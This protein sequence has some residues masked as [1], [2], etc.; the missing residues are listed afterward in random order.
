MNDAI[1]KLDEGKIKADIFFD[2][3]PIVTD[4][5]EV[6]RQV[7]SGIITKASAL[8]KLKSYE[9]LEESDLR[10]H[11]HWID[12][13]RL[14]LALLH[15]AKK[16][17][18]T[19][20]T[21]DLCATRNSDPY[22]GTRGFQSCCLRCAEYSHQEPY[23]GSRGNCAFITPAFNVR[24]Q[25]WGILYYW[26]H[27]QDSTAIMFW[28]ADFFKTRYEAEQA[29]WPIHRYNNW[30]DRKYNNLMTYQRDF[31]TVFPMSTVMQLK[32]PLNPT[33]L[34]EYIRNAIQVDMDKE[35]EMMGHVVREA[36][37]AHESDERD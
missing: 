25:C 32:L 18:E 12:Q 11:Q 8:E 35:H 24:S 4:W 30:L 28:L 5:D 34:R 37:R 29:F 15:A 10:E 1:Q 7:V 26:D 6:R 17:L 22:F 16:P 3:E 20:F 2:R 31:D 27:D 9:L 19:K 14:R 33:E 13:Q 21:C 36:M 23:Y